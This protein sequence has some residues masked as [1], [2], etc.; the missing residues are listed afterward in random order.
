MEEVT[1]ESLPKSAKD[2]FNR[3]FTAIERGNIDYAIEMLSAC[4]AEAP[5]FVRAWKFLRAAEVKRFRK[6]KAASSLS[7]GIET[8]M[9]MPTYLSASGLLKSGKSQ[10]A[11]MMAAKLLRED[12]ENTKYCVLFAQ[13]AVACEIPEVA[14]LTLETCREANPD[15][16]TVLSWLGA[17][18]QKSG[19][20]RSARECF[21]H[22]CELNPNDPAALKQLKDAMA[23][24]SMSNDGW[25]RTVEQ[26][27]SFRDM[28]K[29]EEE[30]AMLEQQA[31]STKS[32]AGS[33]TLIAD[34]M[35]KI[36]AEPKNINYRRALAKLYL[37]KQEFE[38]GIAA[39][40]EAVE[41]N[42]GDPEL[43]RAVTSA[44][45]QYFDSQIEV[46][47]NAGDEDGAVALEH[48]RLQF[49]FDDLQAKVERYP[50]DLQLRFEW[51]VMLFENDYI[52]EAIQQLQIA[53]RSAKNRVMSLYYLG[54][55][56][57]SKNQFEIA[58]RQLETA[59]KEL[60]IMD[61]NKKKVLYELGE[62][63][64][65]M[66]DK[67]KA[68]DAFMQIY[69]SDISYRD[70]SARVESLYADNADKA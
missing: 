3:G 21:E 6:K 44:Q 29:D 65:L 68:S 58:C 37:Q 48:E 4:V 62:L 56:F 61:A 38:A 43:E 50:N 33:D 34:M 8:V 23:L 30:A 20:M 12:P 32:D 41:M 11:L 54:V 39:L 64:L 55:C 53:Q 13:A 24:D 63:A 51:G 40:Q 67:A 10:A 15:D 60:P 5:R 14:I 18:Y 31:K 25:Q 66:N 7:A 45:L 69:Q 9:K 59:I 27:G 49:R 22:L 52:N 19:R 17:F 35:A 16:I 42:P 1:L 57:R 2:F 46:K 47:R 26:G 36:A 28:L 70:V